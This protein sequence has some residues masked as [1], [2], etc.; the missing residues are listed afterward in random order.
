ML[1]L[2]AELY[3]LY[4]NIPKLYN[5]PFI[6]LYNKPNSL[7][8]IIKNINRFTKFKLQILKEVI[9]SYRFLYYLF[10]PK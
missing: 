9:E 2:L 6:L 7:L 3:I 5:N 1:I 4:I 10:Y 8:V